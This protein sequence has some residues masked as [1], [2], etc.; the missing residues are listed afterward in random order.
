M[1]KTHLLSLLLCASGANAG[2][3]L[4]DF[5]PVATTG[6]PQTWN[7]F[8]SITNG[9]I[10]P[11]VDT[12]GTGS[13]ISLAL[14]HDFFGLNED[15]A[16]SGPYAGTVTEDAFFGDDDRT[17]TLSGLNTNL[18]YNLTF[19]AYIARSDSRLTNI[20]IN[21]NT[22]SL[23]PGNGTTTGNSVTLSNLVPSSSG[24]LKIDYTRG[25]AVANLI[26][27]AMEITSVPEPSSTAL[28]GAFGILPL[29]RRRRA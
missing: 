6:T 14:N 17:M 18:T 25:S 20:T 4:V 15:P 1:K 27:S 8:T 23:Q 29:L 16:P 3:V 19:Y 9:S 13:G 2:T 24:T 26:I 7:S 12:L 21:G 28:L 11:L 10:L 5:G 22:V